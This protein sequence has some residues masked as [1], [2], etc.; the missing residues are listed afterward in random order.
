MARKAKRTDFMTPYE[1]R[2]C[3]QI[4]KSDGDKLK[5]DKM[6]QTALKNVLNLENTIQLEDGTEVNVST[7]DML[8]IKRVAYDM[9][10]PQKIDL[11]MYSGVLG[12]NELKLNATLSSQELFGDIVIKPK[13]ESEEVNG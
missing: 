3:S 4:K 5:D 1:R 13:E 12:E 11:K 9:A 2:L 6:L 10:N 7:K 8:V